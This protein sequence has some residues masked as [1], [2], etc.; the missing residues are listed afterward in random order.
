MALLLDRLNDPRHRYNHP[1]SKSVKRRWAEQRLGDAVQSVPKYL[2]TQEVMDVVQQLGTACPVPYLGDGGVKTLWAEYGAAGDR[3]V[4]ALIDDKG[5]GI[6]FIEDDDTLAD[7]TV[8]VEYTPALTLRIKNPEH[9]KGDKRTGEI[10]AQ[11]YTWMLRA[12]GLLQQPKIVDAKP[13]P[14]V[15]HRLQR[16]R[17]KAGK[18]PLADHHV[19]TVHVSKQEQ[20]ARLEAQAHFERTGVRLHRVRS[21]VRVKNGK[22]E[23]VKEH[24][25]GDASLGAVHVDH[26]KVKL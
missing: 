5:G 11:L 3:V 8:K 16:A 18:R 20:A 26:Y 23:R 15:D 14:P 9:L 21:F 17:V 24:W 1:Y 7:F 10:V 4:A 13:S 25:R 2:L 22:L 12:L 19:V 6:I